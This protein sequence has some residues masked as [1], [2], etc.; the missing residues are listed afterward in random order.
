MRWSRSDE[1][2]RRPS[3]RTG[4]NYNHLGDEAART[5]GAPEASQ[6]TIA[7][8]LSAI[9]V[10]QMVIARAQALADLPGAPAYNENAGKGLGMATHAGMPVAAA[11]TRACGELSYSRTY[12]RTVLGEWQARLNALLAVKEKIV[13]PRPGPRVDIPAS[14]LVSQR[15]CRWSLRLSRP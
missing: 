6:Q 12:Y 8:V 5:S 14:D 15:R 9:P 11:F 10:V 13:G 4:S 7:G 1:P 2:P 3:P